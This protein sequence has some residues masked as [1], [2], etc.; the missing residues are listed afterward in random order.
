MHLYAIKIYVA[1]NDK[2]DY[3]ETVVFVASTM[4]R[5]IEDARA[6]KDRKYTDY[7]TILDVYLVAE[8]IIRNEVFSY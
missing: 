5:A 7:T 1:P 2:E 4:D 8:N 3:V 6:Y